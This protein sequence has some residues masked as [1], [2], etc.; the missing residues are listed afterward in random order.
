MSFFAVLLPARRIVF[1]KFRINNP[2]SMAGLTGMRAV[3]A[4]ICRGYRAAALSRRKMPCKRD[5]ATAKINMEGRTLQ[6]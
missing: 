5:M 2:P 6:Y 1:Y 4:V 3:K